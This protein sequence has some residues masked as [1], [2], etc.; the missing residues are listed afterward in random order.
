MS[1]IISDII[2]VTAIISVLIVGYLRYKDSIRLGFS[3]DKAAGLELISGFLI[4]AAGVSA[5]LIV[6]MISG[7]LSIESVSLE[8]GG[9]VQ[10]F[11]FFGIGA[12]VEEVLFRMGL[13]LLL[14]Y[15][16][17]NVWLAIGIQ[18][19][20][21]GVAHLFNPGA[22]LMSLS[23]NTIGG[24][25]YSIAFVSTG[26]IWMPVTLHLSWNFTQGFW[27]FNV[28][29]MDGFSGFFAEISLKGAKIWTGGEYGLEGSVISLLSRTLVIVLIILFVKWLHG[30]FRGV[31]SNRMSILPEQMRKP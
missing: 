20:L 23:S 2:Q 28:S 18:I 21:F 15:M 17:K 13:L 10:S 27:G 14:I 8:S 29:G 16:I 12:F 26:R 19:I 25:M 24:L 22:D 1:E 4:G 6:M 7:F 3:T 30:R 5:G 9:L 11:I 31:S